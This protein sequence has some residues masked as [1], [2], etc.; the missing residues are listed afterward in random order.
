MVVLVHGI[1]AY[2]GVWARMQQQLE[3]DYIAISPNGRK[4]RLM[5]MVSRSFSLHRSLVGI[6]P[7]ANRLTKELKQFFSKQ[8]QRAINADATTI[9]LSI[10]A[11]SMGGLVARAALPSLCPDARCS[12]LRA[13]LQTSSAVEIQPTSF[14]TVGTPHLGVRPGRVKG[15]FGNL[16]KWLIHMSRPFGSSVRELLL[17][18]VLPSAHQEIKQLDDE[19]GIIRSQSY[20]IREMSSPQYLSALEHFSF[21]TLIGHQHDLIVPVTSSVMDPVREDLKAN[22]GTLVSITRMEGFDSQFEKQLQKKLVI[23]NEGKRASACMRLPAVREKDVSIASTFSSSQKS[24]SDVCIEEMLV[25]RL[26]Q[27]SGIELHQMHENQ[28][29]YDPAV[30]KAVTSMSWRRLVLDY[31]GSSNMLTHLFIHNAQIGA[32]LPLPSFQAVSVRL[33]SELIMT[34]FKDAMGQ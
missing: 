8:V 13:M 30:L 12:P 10:M 1:V 20:M 33:L 9:H 3:Q 29:E 23:W 27:K 21:R 31:G 22:S 16:R 4:C 18:D 5:T 11:H 32:L 6:A 19:S 15:F 7:T 24:M 28:M 2:G 14:I 26:R 34:D 17:N 25:K